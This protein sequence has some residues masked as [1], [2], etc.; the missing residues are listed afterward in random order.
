ML[1]SILISLL[2]CVVGDNL[3]FDGYYR[4]MVMLELKQLIAQF[5]A[6]DWEWL[7]QR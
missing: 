4:F 2:L 1:K 6:L 7:K 5:V 3:A